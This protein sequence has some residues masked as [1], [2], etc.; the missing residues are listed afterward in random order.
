M[1]WIL[2]GVLAVHFVQCSW[3]ELMNTGGIPRS[4]VFPEVAT[5][6]PDEW[7]RF[8]FTAAGTPARP[9]FLFTVNRTCTLQLVDLN[10][11]GDRFVLHE[12]Q[13][14]LGKPIKSTPTIGDEC[15]TVKSDP[16]EAFD[17][18]GQRWSRA[19]SELVAGQ[20]Y[21]ITILVDASPL[22]AGIGAVRIS[23]PSI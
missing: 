11:A 9:R 12:A 22:R 4:V 6:T 2:V 23:C 1:L 19:T 17:D 16:N 15:D 14:L 10:C 8:M 3:L 5:P 7:I 13:G 21:N 18:P 20:Q